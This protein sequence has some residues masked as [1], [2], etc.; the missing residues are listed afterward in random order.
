MYHCQFLIHGLVF[1]QINRTMKP[2]V[3]QNYETSSSTQGNLIKK[4]Y[5]RKRYGKYSITVK[6]CW[7]MEQ[8][9][10]TIK[11]YAT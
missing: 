10:K 3:Q 5:K 8:N 4:F 2:Q 1:S 7:V 6:C 9:P 11:S